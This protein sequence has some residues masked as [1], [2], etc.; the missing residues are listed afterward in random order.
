MR[1]LKVGL[2]SVVVAAG[3]ATADAL[4]RAEQVAGGPGPDGD[5]R[6]CEIVIVGS[7]PDLAD[8]V[9]ARLGDRG[10]AVRVPAGTPDVVAR[11]AGAERAR[12]EYLAFV[13]RGATPRERWLDRLRDG[14]RADANVALTTGVVLD[15]AGA[16]VE[17]TPGIGADRDVLH[18]SPSGFFVETK[19]FQWV[20]G[21]DPVHA[22]GV[23]HIDLGWK[24]WIAGF[25]VRLVADAVLQRAH[26]DEPTAEPSAV[27]AGTLSMLVRNSEDEARVRAL[28][29]AIESVHADAARTL[30]ESLPGLSDARAVVQSLRS[31]PDA[32]I[33][34]R[35]GDPLA[36]IAADDAVARTVRA[37][38]ALDAM[39]GGSHRVL[40]VTP[41]VLQPTMAGPAIRAWQM[42][43]A[44]AR[45]HD[46]RLVT[47][48]RCDLTH[49]DFP[50]HHADKA[51]LKRQ[52]RWAEI[53]IF[54]GHVLV[55]NPWMG[56][57][58]TILVADIYDPIHLEV[59]EQAR[60]LGPTARR[61][62]VRDTVDVMNGQLL[63]G[64]FFLCASEKQRDFW[65]GQL[66]GIGRIN[67]ATYDDH[68]NL[69][70][71]I[72]IVP[73]GIAEAAPVPTQPALRGVVPGIAE[74]DKIILWG[75]GVYNW[76]D[77]L[78]LVEAV[79]RVRDR[80]PN[81]R[82]Y[83]MGMKHPNPNVPAMQM[84]YRTRRL[85]DSLGLTGV[86]VFFNED[87]IAYDERH[88]LLL[89]ADIGVSTHLDHI[90]TAFSF[91]TR[92]LDYLWTSL[93]IVATGGDSFADLIE[94]EGLGLTV[95]PGDVEGLEAA[96]FRLLDDDELNA[97]CRRAIA[98]VAA[99]YRWSRVLEPVLAFCRNPS[100]APDRVDPRQRVLTGD[101]IA[102]AMWGR[103]GLRHMILVALGH[104][105]SGEFRDLAYKARIRVRGALAPKR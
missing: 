76:F 19:V 34:P 94:R 101:P 73:F 56:K 95:A 55:D 7:A 104:L 53:V 45:E 38:L 51:E 39:G 66:A 87:W 93:P 41:D 70:D 75:G 62:A 98:G 84:A 80:I 105:R 23:E 37:A 27:L 100:R 79:H 16:V 99:Q 33:I 77:P 26:D 102:A 52:V 29:D 42:A 86:H 81:V 65:L 44:L 2:V 6:P 9:T 13:D 49:D 25:R 54:Q 90:E 14:L 40:I 43:Q 61:Y 22:A 11:N 31:V 21:F 20:G 74:D 32:Q 10:I 96:L 78:T 69:L 68:E 18:P 30:R 57:G 46:V 83:F 72:D 17:P 92:I 63:R 47:T 64:D 71:L 58:D 8:A 89:E 4:D 97:S 12:G 103:S 3:D 36:A 50:V 85:S 28:A 59:L 15:G 60:D 67:P 24:V 48:V 35:V 1:P 88:N 91:R 5:G 82:L